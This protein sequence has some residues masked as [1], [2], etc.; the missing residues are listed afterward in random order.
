MGNVHLRKYG[1]ETTIPFTLFEVGGVDFRVDA[2]ATTADTTV[3]IDE[4][5]ATSVGNLFVDRGTG[6]SITLTAGTLTGARMV[7]YF[8]DSAT[9]V[10][11]D[12]SIVIE[13]YGDPSAMHAFDLD[14]A[15]VAQTGDSFARIGATGSGL[16]SVAQASLVTAA[17][18][19]AL[20]DW[21]NDGRLDL[22][23]DEIEAHVHGLSHGGAGISTAAKASPA[24]FVITEGVSE[25]NTEDVTHALDGTT[26]DI[27][28]ASPNTDVYYE[29]NVGTEGVPIDASWHGYTNGNNATVAVY[30]RD[31]GNTAWV[32]IGSI[33]G[34]PGST[35]ITQDFVL[36]TNLVEV[37]VGT[38]RIR[39]FSTDATKIATDQILVSYTAVLSSDGI[40]DE[41][42]SQSQA[43]PTG[44]R[45]NMMETLGA[46][47][48]TSGTLA[49]D[50]VDA[51]A[52]AADAVAEI[53]SGLAT[54]ALTATASALTLVATPAQVN[55]Q[56]L[57]VMNVDTF[58]EPG[59]GAPAATLSIF[60]KI[61]FIYKWLRNKT[62]TTATT[63]S[64]YNDAG[65]V[66]DQKATVSD[67]SATYTKGE[68]ETGP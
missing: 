66:V 40:V 17:R 59:Q 50:A 35:V 36:T 25:A 58:A 26:H 10:W 21:I 57:N 22:I 8:V 6:Y 44:F 34:E 48:V 60:G 20:T 12:D 65:A 5:A 43:D 62:E 68:I 24:G 27:E 53:Q 56:V 15:S 31:F 37:G 11:L 16:T 61:N 47:A 18:M 7:V 46:S 14:T 45:V 28:D 4:G 19:G 2:V 39:L 3:S 64:I 32:Q 67:D 42:E 51:A 9:K 63:H 13:T 30:G 55:A 1:V 29:F 33:E 38:V 54:S 23:L 52:L 41:W 49:T